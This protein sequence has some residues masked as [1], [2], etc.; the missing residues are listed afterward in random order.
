M[1]FLWR[2]LK[3]TQMTS[4]RYERRCRLFCKLLGREF[5]VPHTSMI[6][7]LQ[8]LTNP[9]QRS[10]N[11]LNVSTLILSLYNCCTV[12]KTIFEKKLLFTF[13]SSEDVE[14]I[15]PTFRS[16]FL[17]QYISQ[18][19]LQSIESGSRWSDHDLTGIIDAQLS[20]RC[21]R[22]SGGI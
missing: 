17:S 21:V 3:I 1:N 10:K 4:Y 18:L 16:I 2:R 20:T 7:K 9:P 13:Q 12:K 8:V 5:V 11:G 15:L 19:P 14:N 6:F 22:V